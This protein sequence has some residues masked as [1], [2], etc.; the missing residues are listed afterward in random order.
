[1]SCTGRDSEKSEGAI[2]NLCIVLYNYCI[3][4]SIV[5]QDRDSILWPT[6]IKS[7]MKS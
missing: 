1:M 2:D 6:S 5:I 4:V 7:S 3:V